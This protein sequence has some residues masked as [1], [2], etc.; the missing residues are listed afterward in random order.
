MAV[1]LFWL[2]SCTLSREEA[3]E[4]ACH[5]I[6]L[7][8][9]LG[10]VQLQCTQ[11]AHSPGTSWLSAIWIPQCSEPGTPGWWVSLL[12]AVRGAGRQRDRVCR[13]WAGFGTRGMAGPADPAAAELAWA[14]SKGTWKGPSRC[15]AGVALATSSHFLG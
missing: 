8:T 3:A 6:G 13:P 7:Q 11:P 1:P 15:Q 9:A 2:E 12:L 5:A 10:R 4:P 14:L